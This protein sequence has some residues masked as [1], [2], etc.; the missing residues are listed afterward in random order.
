MHL[1]PDAGQIFMNIKEYHNA[2]R[3]L[4][5][6]LTQTLRVWNKTGLKRTHFPAHKTSRSVFYMQN[7]FSKSKSAWLLD[8]Q[9]I[10]E[11]EFPPLGLSERQKLLWSTFKQTP[12]ANPSAIIRAIWQE[13]KRARQINK[14]P[15]PIQHA[16][17]V[18]QESGKR[19][20]RFHFT[21]SYFKVIARS[22]IQRVAATVG[23][24]FCI[25]WP[26]TAI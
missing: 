23:Q 24:L 10:G 4:Q 9:H 20:L 3:W 25:V 6:G 16:G 21:L 19:N 13:W 7:S 2:S 26:F 11:G 12:Y 15:D 1:A 8:L 14:V 22:R 17:A 18:K 5:L